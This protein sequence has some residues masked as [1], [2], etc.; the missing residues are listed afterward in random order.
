MDNEKD[1]RKEKGINKVNKELDSEP[2]KKA[3]IIDIEKAV[4]PRKTYIPINKP[5]YDHF[6]RKILDHENEIMP[7]HWAV[8]WSDII[9]LLF[10]MF[11]VLFIYSQ[12]KRDIAD[13]FKTPST[14]TVNTQKQE[15]IHEVAPEKL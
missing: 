14:A 8:S 15:V 13:A 9:M 3:V 12:S 10:I 7:P 11:A 4:G 5:S 1:H 2:Q 6:D